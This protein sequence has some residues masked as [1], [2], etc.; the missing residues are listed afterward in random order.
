MCVVVGHASVAEHAGC[1]PQPGGGRGVAG[2]VLA[3][4][5]LAG[6]LRRAG[7]RRC[8]RRRGRLRSCRGSGG[9][10]RRGRR[11]PRRRARSR[12]G[13]CTGCRSARARGPR[14][15]W[16]PGRRAARGRWAATGRSRWQST[17]AFWRLW[18]SCPIRDRHSTGN[19]PAVK[20][21]LSV[22][23]SCVVMLPSATWAST[24]WRSRSVRASWR[25][26]QTRSPNTITCSSRGDAG[27]RLRGHAAQQRQ[28]VPSPTDRVGHEPLADERGRERGLRVGQRLG[29][30]ARVDEH[31][32]VAE[33]DAL[34]AGEL[35]ERLLGTARS[36]PRAT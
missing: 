12:R 4:G 3:V 14:R 35:G 18:P 27:E 20:R 2:V 22:S 7:S 26:H 5:D 6:D 17:D 34:G 29:V 25:R 11:A 32:D 1:D 31:A 19:S 13:G 16:P 24:P 23:N 28:P 33:H 8:S 30:D 9:A 21:R 36:R 10:R 15:A